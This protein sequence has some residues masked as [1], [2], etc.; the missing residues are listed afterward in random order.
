MCFFSYPYSEDSSQG[1]QYMN[2]RCP[3]W[4]DRILMSPSARDML[5]KVSLYFYSNL[6]TLPS[7]KEQVSLLMPHSAPTT[8]SSLICMPLL[9][10]GTSQMEGWGVCKYQLA[11]ISHGSTQTVY[12]SKHW[13]SSGSRLPHWAADLSFYSQSWSLPVPV[14]LQ[15][16]PIINASQSATSG[17]SA[18]KTQ[19]CL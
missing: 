9:S 3:A 5:L 18:N 16:H 7:A 6:T 2:T 1:K 13:S 4:C 17:I 10:F 8:P 11:M 12:I 19:L 15:I 14:R